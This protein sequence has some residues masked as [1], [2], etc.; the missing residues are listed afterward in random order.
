MKEIHE[1]QESSER[2]FSESQNK[3]NEQK[4]YFTKEME[5]LKKN[6]QIKILQVNNPID[7]M[8]SEWERNGNRM[9][10]AEE[11]VSE[12]EGRNTEVI[13]VE[14]E[15]ALRFVESEENLTP[16]A[17]PTERNSLVVRWLGL[18]E[19]TPGTKVRS[20]VREQRSYKPSGVAKKKKKKKVNIRIMS[21]MTVPA[22]A[23]S[24]KGAECI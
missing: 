19:F 1:L 2:Q 4:E 11:R 18:H 17:E 9:G 16:L 22:T 24:E 23:E 6:K 8:M 13:G 7:K 12:L 10:H 14:K 20:L 3:I 21:V 5:I 15:R